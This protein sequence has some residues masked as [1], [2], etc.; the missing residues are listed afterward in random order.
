MAARDRD[1][2][3]AKV[4]LKEIGRR[5]DRHNDHRLKGKLPRINALSEHRIAALQQFN[6]HRSR[7]SLDD[8]AGNK[9]R[10][11]TYL[12]VKLVRRGNK[13]IGMLRPP[14]PPA[15]RI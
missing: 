7:R 15:I 3:L 6:R 5:T 12:I 4:Q 8:C 9:T 2:M 10:G 1:R 13:G 11:G 14:G